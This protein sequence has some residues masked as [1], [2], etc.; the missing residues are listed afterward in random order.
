MNEIP[1]RLLR[2]SLDCASGGIG[3]AGT[4][5]QG[6]QHTSPRR[7]ELTVR[8]LKDIVFPT[9]PMPS[10]LL[11]AHFRNDLRGSFAEQVPDPAGRAAGAR[12]GDGYLI[13]NFL[14]ITAVD[15]RVVLPS[16]RRYR[17]TETIT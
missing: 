17:N 15:S 5:G 10:Q 9:A 7:Y 14:R 3:R 13:S 2:W 6:L 1:A 16:Q 8:F 4:R 12:R 11:L